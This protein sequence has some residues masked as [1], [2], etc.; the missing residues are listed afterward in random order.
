MKNLV[1]GASGEFWLFVLTYKSSRN[2]I[3]YVISSVGRVVSV[4]VFTFPGEQYFDTVLRVERMGCERTV[5]VEAIF[6]YHHHYYQS[7]SYQPIFDFVFGLFTDN[8]MSV[9]EGKGN[10]THVDGNLD[11]LCSN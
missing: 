6:H 8:T 2:V 3:V 4:E 5:L 11:F 1:L 9:V 10:K 7:Y